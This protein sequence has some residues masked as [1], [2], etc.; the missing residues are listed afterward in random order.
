MLKLTAAVFILALADP[1]AATQD[2]QL[3]RVPESR[4]SMTV[5][6]V[7]GQEAILHF[8]A[9]S[10]ESLRRVSILRPDGRRLAELKPRNAGLGGLSRVELEFREADPETLFAKYP[11]GTYELRGFTTNGWVTLGSASLLRNLPAPPQVQHPTP[12]LVVGHAGLT[13][14]W[15][16]SKDV[17]AYQVEIEREDGEDE[18]GDADDGIRV[19]LPPA[20]TSF[21]VP[22]GLIPPDSHVVLEV[23]AIGSGGNRTAVEVVFRTTR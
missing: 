17:V 11:A 10:D 7:P 23:T 2:T 15:M 18:D 1:V 16:R 13:V 12:D 14:A 20:Q 19:R 9:E 8:V 3:P 21:R 4:C 6:W 22:D 5:E